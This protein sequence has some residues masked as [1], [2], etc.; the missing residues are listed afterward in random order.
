MKNSEV[1]IDVEQL[2]SLIRQQ[3]RGAQGLAQRIRTER[4]PCLCQP[5]PPFC[6]GLITVLGGIEHARLQLPACGSPTERDRS[7]VGQAVGVSLARA[8]LTA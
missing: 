7:Q 3:T 6:P 2:A 8:V 1:G 4:S 5:L